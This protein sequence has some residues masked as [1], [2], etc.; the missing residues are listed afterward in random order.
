MIK[1]KAKCEICGK[2]ME[3]QFLIEPNEEEKRG[4]YCDDYA[5]IGKVD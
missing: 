5:K 3:L 1:V 2:E 4:W